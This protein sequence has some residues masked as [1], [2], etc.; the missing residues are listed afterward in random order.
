VFDDSGLP[1][2]PGPD[3]LILIAVPTLAVPG[4]LQ[5]LGCCGERRRERRAC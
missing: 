2:N 1:A 3:D 5:E 4:V